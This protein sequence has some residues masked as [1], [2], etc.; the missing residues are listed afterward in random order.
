MPENDA[1]DIQAP[2]AG[3]F[4]YVARLEASPTL[5]QFLEKFRLLRRIARHT[6]LQGVDLLD[7]FA[8]V[9]ELAVDARVPD[10]SDVIDLLKM[11]HH[12]HADDP[13]RH[14]AMPLGL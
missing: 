13:G 12:L 11:L 2:G 1:P 14:F 7:E 9:L 3:R 10:E 8:H 4:R 5:L 6:R